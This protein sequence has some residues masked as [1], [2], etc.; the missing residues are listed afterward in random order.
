MKCKLNCVQMLLIFL[1][2]D[3]LAS[4]K[5][6]GSFKRHDCIMT[7]IFLNLAAAVIVLDSVSI[8]FIAVIKKPDF[9]KKSDIQTYSPSRKGAVKT[10]V[11]HPRPTQHHACVKRKPTGD[12]RHEELICN[13]AGKRGHQHAIF[14]L[15]LVCHFSFLRIYL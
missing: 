5:I 6:N 11:R 8:P 1:L 4:L 15:V 7:S 3:S 13:V 2:F 10:T 9:T 14:T 12:L